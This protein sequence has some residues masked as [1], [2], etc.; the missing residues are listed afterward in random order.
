PLINTNSVNIN[1]SQKGDSIKRL[2]LELGHASKEN[3]L[4]S[5]SK[6]YKWKGITSD[7]NSFIRN[8]NICQM[9]AGIPSFSKNKAII[10]SKIHELIEVDL[11][12]PLLSLDGQ[13]EYIL[14]V[15]DHYSKYI[16]TCILKKKDQQ[17]VWNAHKKVWIDKH[18]IPVMFYSDMGREFDNEYVRKQVKDL[19]SEWH[20]NSPDNHQAV[21]C[22]ERANQTFFRKFK[23]L[24][25]FG[26]FD[27]EPY[28][29]KATA[30][31]NF[32][33]NRAINTCPYFV[34]Y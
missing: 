27:S 30:A 21:G 7:I 11:I 1:L 8:C 4:Y 18:G 15:I 13:K 14:L 10:T 25:N 2:H 5:L 28:V 29:K 9:G 3:M 6:R 32:S 34:M 16:E 23:K 17:L 20:Y 22:V 31:T 19:G 24:S 33:F 26:T 12:G